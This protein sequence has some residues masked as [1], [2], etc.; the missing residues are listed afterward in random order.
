[1]AEVGS[2]GQITGR[3]AAPAPDYGANRIR[4]TVKTT[5]NTAASESREAAGEKAKA[6]ALEKRREE[7]ED[8]IAKSEDGDT[9]QASADA[10]EKLDEDRNVGRVVEKNSLLAAKETEPE[11]KEVKPE[12]KPEVKEVKPEEKEDEGSD[13]KVTSY[14]GYTEAQLKTMVNKGKISRDSYNREIEKR[15]SEREDK[16]EESEKLSRDERNNLMQADRNNRDEL[17][18]KGLFSEN[19]AEEPDAMLR[20]GIIDGLDASFSAQN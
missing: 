6:E 12:A 1:M 20:A 15:D 11:K 4:S 18:F 17:E 5:E 8:L 13:T 19:S 2:I 3:A 16:A 9:V 10:V 7:L 14:A